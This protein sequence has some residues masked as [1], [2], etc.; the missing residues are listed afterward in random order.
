[1]QTLEPCQS[2]RRHVAID[3]STCPFCHSAGVVLVGEGRHFLHYR[4]DDCAEVWTAQVDT[5]ISRTR[6]Q[7]AGDRTDSVVGDEVLRTR[8]CLLGAA[9]VG[10][11]LRDTRSLVSRF[12]NEQ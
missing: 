6:S 8:G 2:C 11:P 12:E 7:L 9:A 10:A 3:A 1:M 4:C 5:P